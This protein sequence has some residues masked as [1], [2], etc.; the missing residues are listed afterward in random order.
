MPSVAARAGRKQ[1]LAKALLPILVGAAV[2][3]ACGQHQQN[4]PRVRF[5]GKLIP[6]PP[7]QQQPWT[8]P[9]TKLSRFLV[10]TTELLFQQ[11]VADP[12]GC[13]YRQVE[14]APY[15]LVFFEIGTGK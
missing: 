2:V 4:P 10:T 14:I 9:A 8:A 5:E 1:L 15:G 7:A 12:R 11:G 3:S 6:K 13:P